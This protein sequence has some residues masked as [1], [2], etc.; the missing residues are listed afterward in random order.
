MVPTREARK[1]W[2]TSTWP[3]VSSTS[4]GSSMPSMAARSSSI[5]R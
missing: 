4:S 5:A 2:R 3:T 1:I